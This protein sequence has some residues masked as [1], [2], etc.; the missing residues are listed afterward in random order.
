MADPFEGMNPELTGRIQA[1]IA[2]S[3]GRVRPGSGQRSVE[4]QVAL[5]KKNGCPDV[6]TSPASACR[7]PTAIPGRS[8]HNHGLAMDL[9]F[10][11]DG[12]EWAAQNAGRFGLHFPVRGENWHV[13]MIDDDASREHMQG[14][15]QRGAIGFDTRWQDDTRQPIDELHDRLAAIGQMLGAGSPTI[16]APEQMPSPTNPIQPP[17][18]GDQPLRTETTSVGGTPGA[19]AAPTATPVGRGV[20]RWRPLVVQALQ[21]VGE[22]PSEQNISA[23]LRRMAQESGG[24]PNVVQ[25]INDVN[26]RNGTPAIGLM[27]VIG[28]TFQA[29]A[30]ELA[31]L[32]QRDPFANLVASMRYAKGRYGS[33][34]AGYGRA[35]G[36]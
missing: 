13:E 20:E 36:Y 33:L 17:A 31:S 21:Y 14:A 22:E 9:T 19:G 8:N 23:T 10:T 1:L 6:W 3:G 18:M 26:S 2:A 27:Q 7:V 28:P 16:P 4:E 35:G 15:Q 11:G 25:R 30:G 32:G 29:H 12:A 34:V 5:R 24:D